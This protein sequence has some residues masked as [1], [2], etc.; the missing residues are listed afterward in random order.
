[1]RIIKTNRREIFLFALTVC[2]T[3]TVFGQEKERKQPPNFYR[4]NETLYRGG[5][6]DADGLKRLK[7]LG[8]KTI[9]NLR[10]DDERARAEED[11]ARDLGFSYFSLPLAR[12]NRPSD[13]TVAEVLTVINSPQNQPVFVH[14]KRGADRTGIIIA[15]YRMEHDGW[16]GEEAKAE[17]K[18]FGL[19]FWQVRMKNYLDDYYRRKLDRPKTPAYEPQKG[20]MGL[21]TRK[22]QIPFSFVADE[23]APLRPT[24]K[25]AFGLTYFYLGDILLCCLRKSSKQPA[26]NGMWLFTTVDD[27]DSLGNEFPE[28]SRRYRWRSGTNAWVILPAKLEHFEE[29]AFKACEM[30]LS[31]DRRIGRVSRTRAPRC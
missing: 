9:I 11:A 23:L 29:Y 24:I 8:I 15:I 16:T 30:M 26:T 28:L 31:G 1:M 22:S 7:E 14:C 25:Q 12:F 13:E 2:L 21:Q 18:S 6:P 27:V 19:G 10:D 17:A 5:Q 4:I 20:P 3:Q